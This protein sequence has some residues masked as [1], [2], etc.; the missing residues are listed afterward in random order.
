LWMVRIAEGEHPKIIREGDYFT[1][2]GEYSVGAQASETMLNSI[3][4]K[5]SY[6]RFGELRIGYNQPAGFDRTRGYVIGRKDI[7]LEYLE[8][9]YTTENWLV[10][11]YKVVHPNNRPNIKYQDRQV[12]SKKSPSLPKKN[13]A[14]KKGVLNSNPT[15]VKGKKPSAA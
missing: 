6:Y 2:S 13:K 11:I 9:A 1:E 7:S 4:Y 15:V 5:M 10:R 12:K 14:T 3:M 8:E